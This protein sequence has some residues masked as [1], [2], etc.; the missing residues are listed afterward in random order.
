MYKYKN[1][2]INEFSIYSF[3]GDHPDDLGFGIET[4]LVTKFE[5]IEILTSLN[6]FNVFYNYKVPNEYKW[7]LVKLEEAGLNNTSTLMKVKLNVVLKQEFTKKATDNSVINDFLVDPII[8]KELEVIFN[9]LRE[10]P[11][12]ISFIEKQLKNEKNLNKFVGGGFLVNCIKQMLTP[13]E[14]LLLHDTR[15]IKNYNKLFFGLLD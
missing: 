6:C 4:I 10:F 12:F 8:R 9:L 14:L 5:T 2:R 15:V 3:I 13:E 1:P 11:N 7:N